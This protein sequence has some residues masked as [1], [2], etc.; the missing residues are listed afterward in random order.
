VPRRNWTRDET[1]LAFRLYN[2]TQYGRIHAGNEDII[3]LAA[4]LH[5]T[6]NAVAKKMLN[7]ASFDPAHLERGVV[8]LQHTSRLDREIWDTFH[9]RLQDLYWASD[10]GLRRLLEGDEQAILPAVFDAPEFRGPTETMRETP[11]RRAQRFFREAVLT[12][13]N[14]RCAVSGIDRRELLTASHII[15]WRTDPDRRTDP[16]NGLALSA[17]HDRAFD[18]GLIAF[19]EGRAM[20]VS[21]RLKSASQNEVVRVGFLELEGRVLEASS[22]YAPD[23]GALAYHRERLFV[24]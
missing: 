13:Y 2:L 24:G 12:A 4:L 8:S 7:L 14:G 5:R 6:P 22:R 16:T 19:D 21:D 1:L 20:L 17:L 18:R 23:P 15:P 3:K 9:A 10:A 11:V